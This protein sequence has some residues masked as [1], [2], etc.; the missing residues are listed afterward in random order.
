MGS[1]DAATIGRGPY[2]EGD[3]TLSEPVSI[4][5]GRRV[6]LESPFMSTAIVSQYTDEGFAIAADSLRK[7]SVTGEDV[8]TRV[9]KIFPIQEEQNKRFLAYALAGAVYILNANGTVF[10]FAQEF[11]TA[12]PKLTSTRIHGLDN[13]GR[14][15]AELVNERLL[16]ERQNGNLSGYTSIPNYPGVMARVIF[17]GYYSDL[18]CLAQIDFRHDNQTLL[19]PTLTKLAVGPTSFE[20]FSGSAFICKMIFESRDLR[21]SKYR[22]S[23]VRKRR[24]PN[25]LLEAKEL[26]RN[27]IQAC[28][29]NHT[30]DRECESIG[31]QPQIATVSPERGFEW[32]VEPLG[33][34]PP[35]QLK[36]SSSVP[37]P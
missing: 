28:I 12:V 30:R 6:S 3:L 18:G 31:G 29:D 11:S 22:T 21:F 23:S 32:F 27:Y 9:Q 17:V 33:L 16:I 36:P 24:P 34:D 25:T 2:W 13:Y 14:R 1:M 35:A 4:T 7:H 5:F 26:V 19:P 20:V 8:S 37:D 10:D 15:L